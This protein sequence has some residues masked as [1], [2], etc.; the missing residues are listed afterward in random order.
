MCLS[1]DAGL[2]LTP[3]GGCSAAC[4]AKMYGDA[5]SA[6]CQPCDPGCAECLGPGDDECTACIGGLEAIP[7]ATAPHA[8]VSPCPSGEFRQPGTTACQ[9]CDGAC[10]ECTGPT[11]QDCW[12]C[13]GTHL[14]EGE[15][16]Q[17]CAPK[18]VPQGGRCL[19]CHLSCD[20][21]SGTRST[22]CTGACPPGLVALPQEGGLM[23]C[24]A[25]CPIGY[26]RS[27]T[28]CVK[29][30]AHCA[31]CPGSANACGQCERGW[32]LN[33]AQEQVCLACPKHCEACAPGGGMPACT[34]LPDGALS[35]PTVPS[36]LRCEAPYLLLENG[37]SCVPACPAGFFD[38]HEPAVPVCGPCHSSC[39]TCMG[40]GKT[41]CLTNSPEALRR[42]RLALGLGLGFGVLLLLL[43]LVL[44]LLVYRRRAA[45]KDPD[46]PDEDATVLNTI[47]ELSL[48]GSIQ[49]CLA[50]DF[51]PLDAPLGAGGQASVFAAR[52]VGAGISARLGCPDTVAIKQL[53]AST[54]TASRAALFQNEVALMW[55][56]RQQ[57]NI[58][59]IYGYSDRP[60]AIV[61]ER[62]DA[63][64]AGLL[65]S[66]VELSLHARLDLATQWAT[67]LEAMHAAGIAHGDLKPGNVFVTQTAGSW[68]AALGDLGTSRSLQADRATALVATAP[69]LNALSARYAAP[70]VLEAFHRRRPLPRE[71]LPP[72]DIYAAAI[73]LWEC[74]ARSVPWQGCSFRD[75]ADQVAAGRRPD[76]ELATGPVAQASPALAQT[77][78]GTLPLL[79]GSDTG[80]RPLAAALR[81]TV[82][83][84]RAM[85]PSQ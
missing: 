70:E 26:T 11:D 18:H 66:E 58:V 17:E 39:A 42:M 54:L 67:G 38:D 9:P 43:A 27:S 14:Q 37:T 49:V 21:C 77:L 51:A 52:A 7:A 12:R 19:P 56:L 13:E 61:M 23:S 64:L 53:K 35:C 24:V 63:D 46:T 72:A 60:P 62:F 31:S 44:V 2:F 82:A 45:S 28:E 68:Y 20:A 25:N 48:P 78:A 47:V 80:A 40:P 15:C 74:L 50:S 83:A 55:L 1:C 71:A 36:C 32:F 76:V 5:P 79:W 10:A 75:I 85:L 33:D 69:E 22:Q 57:P 8:C 73:L 3:T 41:D 29:C 59:H 81:H 4:P 16:V 65:H 6:S 84:L 30:A 34:I